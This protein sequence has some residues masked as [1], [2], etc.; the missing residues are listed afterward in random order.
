[1][2]NQLN[3][4]LQEACEKGGAEGVYAGFS[5]AVSVMKK[6]V[7]YR[8]FFSGGVT[9]YDQYGLNVDT[10]TLFDLASLTKPLCTTLST[11]SLIAAGKIHWHDTYLTF[12]DSVL[13]P[14][15]K[16]I[17][18]QEILHH[19]SGLPAYKPYFME[20]EPQASR[21]NILPVLCKILDEP[22]V[23]PSGTTCLYSDL[24]FILLGHIIERIAEQSLDQFYRQ[25]ILEPLELTNHLGFVPLN[26]YSGKEKTK[27]AATENCPWRQTIVQGEVDDEHCWLMGGV[28]GHAGLFGTAEGV[29]RLCECLLD[30]WQGR[31]NHSA[32]PNDLLRYALQRINSTDSWCL[33]FD[34]PSPG[35]S[36]S[37]RYFSPRSVGH[38]GFTGTSFW[39][40][41]ERDLIV[42]L[43]TNRVHPSRKNIKIKEFR[44]FFHD[45]VSERIDM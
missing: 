44:P 17:T 42:V 21:E 8:G 37:G 11:L 38:L 39:I 45:F 1:M 16:Q 15:N 25:Q 27:I 22:L 28:A 24:G 41:P 34:T 19:S 12:L 43:L 10:S 7:R 32:F 23:Y 4:I 31:A 33:G 30:C 13:V 26:Q 9:R 20:F 40:D 29:L 2:K 3:I 5:A 35:Q 6:K 36:S 18:I 14:R